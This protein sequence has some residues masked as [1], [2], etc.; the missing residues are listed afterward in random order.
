MQDMGI[1]DPEIVELVN[2]IED[3]ERKLHAHPLHKVYRIVLNNSHILLFHERFEGN[4]LLTFFFAITIS[5]CK[6][7][8][9]MCIR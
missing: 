1:K 8:L 4:M 7:S 5:L 2:Q 9:K 3:L 6:C